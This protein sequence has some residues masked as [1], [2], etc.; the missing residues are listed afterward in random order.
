MI[1]ED[2][3]SMLW[4]WISG[5]RAVGEKWERVDQAIA[6]IQKA[7]QVGYVERKSKGRKWE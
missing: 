4:E 7:D 3:M 1:S 6:F 5:A 2:E